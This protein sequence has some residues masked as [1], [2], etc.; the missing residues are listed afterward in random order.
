MGGLKLDY[1]DADKFLPDSIKAVVLIDYKKL[2]HLRN[3]D[4]DRVT[5][6]MGADGW[7]FSSMAVQTDTAYQYYILS[8]EIDMDEPSR[9]AY[10]SKLKSSFELSN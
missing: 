4:I 9:E 1:F 3:A 5:L 8:K 6:L 10:L 2:F 7:K